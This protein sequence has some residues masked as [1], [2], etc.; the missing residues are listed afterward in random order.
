MGY[1]RFWLAANVVFFHGWYEVFY[2]TGLLS[3]Y[4]F[5][6]ISGFLITRIC[7]ETYALS[8]AGQSRFFLNR[9]LRIYPLYFVSL[10]FSTLIIYAA[11]SGG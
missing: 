1:L 5:F 8:F 7:N 3:V 9:L 2:T 6:A 10:A 11:S 4:C